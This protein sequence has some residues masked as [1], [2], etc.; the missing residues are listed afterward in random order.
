[1]VSNKDKDMQEVLGV[2]MAL[3]EVLRVFCIGIAEKGI[4]FKNFVDMG[5]QFTFSFGTAKVL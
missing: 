5:L 4:V 2:V 3:K 1:V